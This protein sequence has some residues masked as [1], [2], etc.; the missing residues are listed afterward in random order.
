MNWLIVKTAFRKEP[1]VTTALNRMGLTAWHPVQVIACRPAIARRVSSKAHLATYRELPILPR[2]VFV[3]GP[4]IMDR[5]LQSE[6]RTLRYV[7]GIETGMDQQLV[8]IPDGQIS[9]FRAV[10]EAEN[11]ASLALVQA[12]SRKQKAKW[13]SLKDALLE[14]VESAK[15]QMEQA[16]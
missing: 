3:T 14:M 11:T 1:Y 16:A 7:D 9:A 5:E 12:R 2:R 6:L 13:R 4:A 15:N 10:V 8:Q